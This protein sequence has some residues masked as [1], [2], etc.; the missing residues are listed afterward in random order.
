ME[1]LPSTGRRSRAI[2][3]G[4]ESAAAARMA[5]AGSLGHPWDNGS[6]NVGLVCKDHLSGQ[7]RYF[8]VA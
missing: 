5:W 7:G 6:I 3:E 1:P 4:N 8:Q 2:A